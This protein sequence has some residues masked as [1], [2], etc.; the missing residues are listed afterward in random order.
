M[1]AIR[2][3]TASVIAAALLCGTVGAQEV[4]L[5]A[6]VSETGGLAA[7]SDAAFDA[8]GV[9]YVLEADFD[10][11]STLSADGETAVVL[12]GSGDGPGQFRD[13]RALEF[14][15]D[16]RLYVADTGNHRI[17]VFE[18]PRLEFVL[19]IGSIG[20]GLGDLKSP[21]GLAV[22]DT[23][24]YVADSLN[25]RVEVFDRDGRSVR[26]LGL[27][28]SGT[29]ELSRPTDVA[30]DAEGNTYVTDAW[31]HRVQKFDAD[32][33]PVKAWGDFGPHPGFLATPM[34][35]THAA[36]QLFVADRDNHRVQVFDTDG[37]L[38][39]SWGLHA[40]RPRESAGKLHYPNRVAVTPDGSRAA[41]LEGFEN[42]LQVFGPTEDGAEPPAA[43][44]LDRSVAAHYGGAV[45][46]AG[47]WMTLVEPTRPA[48]LIWDDATRVA[49]LEPISVSRVS[50]WGRGFGE[51][52]MPVD[53]AVDVERS[54]LYVLDPG[55]LRLAAWRIE[56]DEGDI[57]YQPDLLVL[58]FSLDLT[59]L[60]RA[61]DGSGPIEG[62]AIEVAPAGDD[63]V[64]IADAR[65]RSVL[66]ISTVDGE[67][68]AQRR[69][70]TPGER[71]LLE[72]TDLALSADG[73]QLYVADRVAGE[74]RVFPRTGD[75]EATAFRGPD[76]DPLVRP[77]GLCVDGDGF[78]YVTDAA[79]H[80][81]SKF[82]PAGER[83]AVWGTEGLGALEFFKP[84]GIALRSDGNL[85][86]LDH[87]NH[88]GQILSRDGE[89]LHVFGSLLFIRPAQR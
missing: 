3:W 8:S 19:S 57:K 1:I 48:A 15:P 62:T 80:R 60:P 82:D 21:T 75:G 71:P 28:G 84:R 50:A 37:A 18:G 49:E 42:R 10:R 22:S 27:R 31:N 61:F 38:L 88:R 73:S 70:P 7:P 39:Y 12:G 65:S 47:G 77:A 11:I 63:A 17:Q 23:H 86:V 67:L 79:R 20:T 35:I 40:I 29:G 9:L 4:K 85:V 13:P 64:L 25:D 26:T 14:G 43:G 52:R 30:V 58:A 36:G 53:A 83:V 89:F 45:D 56:R 34:G 78:V 2:Q 24:I 74:V 16:G 33:E 54:L 72:A 59:V 41:V 32:G 55:N 87:G 46:S 44:S 76:D 81:I 51:F 5:G 69:W 66:E 6:Y 68:G